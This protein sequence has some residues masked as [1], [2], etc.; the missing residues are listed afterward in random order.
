VN[1][2]ISAEFTHCDGIGGVLCVI[3]SNSIA[4]I[5]KLIPTSF[6][7]TRQYRILL[8]KKLLDANYRHPGEVGGAN[9]S[10]N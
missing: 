4:V 1:K 6:D 9:E 3:I 5:V 7:Y 8:K 2:S 10:E